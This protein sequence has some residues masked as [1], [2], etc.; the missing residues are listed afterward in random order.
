MNKGIAQFKLQLK[1]IRCGKDWFSSQ[2]IRLVIP[3]LRL[4]EIRCSDC[5]AFTKHQNQYG[6][7]ICERCHEEQIHISNEIYQ[8]ECRLKEQNYFGYPEVVPTP[9]FLPI[10][11]GEII[12]QRGEKFV[13]V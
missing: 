8:H 11:Q 4:E 5:G 7:G 6:E 10:K 12:K 3:P 2:L 1:T 13:A 9:E